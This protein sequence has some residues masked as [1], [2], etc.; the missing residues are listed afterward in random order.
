MKRIDGPK[1]TRTAERCDRPVDPEGRSV[2]LETRIV[3][4]EITDNNGVTP[5][6][7]AGATSRTRGAPKFTNSGLCFPCRAV[8]WGRESAN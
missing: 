7:R 6:S 3:P 2:G 8:L 1:S 4:V 5:I